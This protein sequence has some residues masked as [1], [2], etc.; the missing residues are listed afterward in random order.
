MRAQTQNINRSQGEHALI[1]D[2]RINKEKMNVRE[3]NLH[4]EL[5]VGVKRKQVISLNIPKNM[6]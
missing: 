6:E 1:C 4:F 2:Y 3:N 5:T